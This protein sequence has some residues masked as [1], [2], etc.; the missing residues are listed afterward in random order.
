MRSNEHP[1]TSGSGVVVSL[2]GG[3]GAGGGGISLSSGVKERSA[4]C[5]DAVLRVD[6]ARV[7]W[8]WER[9]ALAALGSDPDCGAWKNY[10]RDGMKTKKKLTVVPDCTNLR[11]VG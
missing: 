6:L 1:L 4:A 9:L 8:G 3:D 2:P 10:I 5:H 7:G 11:N